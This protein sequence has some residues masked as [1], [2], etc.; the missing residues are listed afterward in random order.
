MFLQIVPKRD[1]IVF[2][3]RAEVPNNATFALLWL[4]EV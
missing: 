4:I 3:Y 2:T 1:A